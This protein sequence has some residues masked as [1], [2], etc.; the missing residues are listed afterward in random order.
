MSPERMTRATG[1]PLASSTWDDR[2]FGAMQRVI[3]SGR[4]TMGSEVA[5]FEDAFAQYVGTKHA[6]MV[7]SGSSANLV[8]LAALRY[9]SKWSAPRTGEV[10]VPAVSWGTTYYPVTQY[11]LTLRFVDVAPRD[12][13]LDLAQVR[14]AIND[15]TVG[16]FAVNLLGA[17]AALTELRSLCSDAGLFL[18]EDNC[19]ALGAQV[20][21]KMTGSIGIAGTH[22]CFFSHHIST[23]EGGLVTTDDDELCDLMVSLRA[24]GWLRGLGSDNHVHPLTGNPF[25]DTFTFA[26]PG[27][28]LRPLELSG[29]IGKEQ[30][31][32]LPALL[33]Q[34]RCNAEIFLELIESIPWLRPQ[35]P[36]GNSSWFGFGMVLRE[37]APMTRS[38]LAS[39]LADHNIEC[40][41]IVSGNF[42]RQ[43]VMTH[44]PHVPVGDL[45]VA[46]EL[47]DRGLFV[48]N[49][50]FPL[51]AE[52]ELLRQ[53]LV[54][55]A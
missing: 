11:G 42:T 30:L 33:E 15:Q 23:M 13:N 55:V 24:H 38:A 35:S 28:N 26:L 7:N 51:D 9:H 50:H 36:K 17:P 32:K 25:E 37:D 44:L 29:A 49:H 18:I 6:V 46:D 20:E 41:P 39:A 19:E 47:H 22:S 54:S 43:P 8:L 1:Y 27:Y 10:I 4:F 5:E 14:D 52:L 21:G 48:G 45:R 12:W 40:R 2:E 53:V 16:V 3:D 34:R 31:S